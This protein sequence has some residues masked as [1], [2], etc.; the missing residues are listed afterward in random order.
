MLSHHELATL[1]LLGDAERRLETIDPDVLALRRYELVEIR[2][3]EPQ[4]SMLQLTR[5]GR[6]LL[7]RLR[8]GPAQ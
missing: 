1:M 3:R 8:I 2:Q 5:Q 4:G 7:D 6:A